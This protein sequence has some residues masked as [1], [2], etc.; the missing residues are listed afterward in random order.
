MSSIT[1][2]IAAMAPRAA[3]LFGCEEQ[4]AERRQPQRERG[5]AA[6]RRQG[7]RLQ[8]AEV[9]DAA[10]AVFERVAVQ[11]LAPEAP[12][13]HADAVVR[14]HQRSEIAHDEDHLSAAAL[15][16]ERDN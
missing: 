13:R 6:V 12:A 7:R 5:K 3:V 1:T 15:A 14:A 4:R 8:S 2:R 9:A 16:Q 10:A 11:A